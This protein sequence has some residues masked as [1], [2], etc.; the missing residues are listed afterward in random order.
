MATPRPKFGEKGHEGESMGAYRK[1]IADW[2]KAKPGGSEEA[3]D[4]RVPKPAP[5]PGDHR[6]PPQPG[7][8][9]H[10]KKDKA[11]NEYIFKDGRYQLVTSVRAS[12]QRNMLANKRRAKKE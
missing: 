2:E 9:G 12:A 10:K 5:T 8:E 4:R 6:G 3:P 11:G 7:E 1:R